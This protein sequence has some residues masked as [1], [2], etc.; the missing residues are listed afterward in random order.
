MQ[1]TKLPPAY[2]DLMTESAAAAFLNISLRTLQRYRSAGTGPTYRRIGERR[3]GY[4]RSDV[5]AFATRRTFAPN[6]G[7]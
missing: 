1:T 4:M 6:E 3:L 7:K 2:D 5:L